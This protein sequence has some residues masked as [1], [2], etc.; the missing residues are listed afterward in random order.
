MDGDKGW[1]GKVSGVRVREKG[2]RAALS[3]VLCDTALTR[4]YK[5]MCYLLETPEKS[6]FSI[7]T[8]AG[9]YAELT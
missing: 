5:K 2:E 7:K 3:S 8:C 6:D 4:N 9:N 1:K